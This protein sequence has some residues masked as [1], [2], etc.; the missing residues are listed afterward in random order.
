MDG[1]VKAG[2]AC[3]TAYYVTCPH[4]SVPLTDPRTGSHMI[5]RDSVE[6][7]AGL[8]PTPTAKGQIVVAC[9]DCGERYALPAAVSR[10]AS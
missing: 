2:H 5:G 9:F 1:I 7:F 10:L 3:V 8:A 6:A 4:C